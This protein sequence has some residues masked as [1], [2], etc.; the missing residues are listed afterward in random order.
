MNGE[1][2]KVIGVTKS[3]ASRVLDEV[4]FDLR[5]GEVHALVGENGAG[6]STLAKIIAGVTQ[7]DSGTLQLKRRSYAPHS[8]RDAEH[9]GVRLVMQELNL[10]ANLSV[11]ENVFFD[12]M[13]HRWGWVRYKCLNARARLVMAE[14]GLDGLDPGVPISSL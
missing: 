10:I 2:L 5:A 8:K 3:Y 14:V 4:D 12:Q 6:K 11:A 1:L 13:P 7:P 9:H